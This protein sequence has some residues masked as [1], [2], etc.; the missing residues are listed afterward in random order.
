MRWKLEGREKAR[1]EEIS[2]EERGWGQK[3]IGGFLIKHILI[4]EARGSTK[5][6]T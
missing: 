2:K 5:V 1:T 6:A 4:T 3:R